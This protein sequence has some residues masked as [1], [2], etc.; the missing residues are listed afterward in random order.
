[1][2]QDYEFE[3]DGLKSLSNTQKHGIS[4][5][6][7]TAIWDDP[8]FIEV[9]LISEPEDRWAVV[10]QI[11]KGRYLTAIITYRGDKVRIISVRK[12]T[13]KEIEIYGGN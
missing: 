4:F 6:D 11:A 1:M 10:G 8:L 13:K 5:E 3:W 9:H 7:A 2:K 12:A